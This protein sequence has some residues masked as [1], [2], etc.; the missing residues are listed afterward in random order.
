MGHE[1]ATRLL[2]FIRGN[3]AASLSAISTLKRVCESR[4]RGDYEL[5]VVDVFQDP[6]LV[7]SH[8]I[9]ATPTVLRVSPG[10][11]RRLVGALSEDRLIDGLGLRAFHVV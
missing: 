7:E 11:E 6:G 8:R 2:L 9:L 10:R 1:V 5:R 4:L 3:A